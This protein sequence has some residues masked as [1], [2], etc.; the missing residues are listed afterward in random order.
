MF[1]LIIEFVTTQ[2]RLYYHSYCTDANRLRKTGDAI[3]KIKFYNN[4]SIFEKQQ[5]YKAGMGLM[6]MQ[7]KKKES[8]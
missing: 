1:I 6:R 5:V 4:I 2:Q 3:H 8:Y 7:L